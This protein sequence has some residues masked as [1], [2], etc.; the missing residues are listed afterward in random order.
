MSKGGAHTV[1]V[2]LTA[3]YSSE[4]GLNT[5]LRSPT[6]TLNLGSGMR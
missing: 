3:S 5:L 1:S 2:S 6:E 4:S